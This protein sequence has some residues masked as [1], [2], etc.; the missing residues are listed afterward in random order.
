MKNGFKFLGI[1]AFVAIIGLSMVACDNPTNGDN[2]G[3]GN[4]SGSGGGD[5]GGG[6]GATTGS[7]RVY[8]RTSG[9]IVRITLHSQSTGALLQTIPVNMPVGGNQTIPN[10]QPGTYFVSL[11]D[12]VAVPFPVPVVTSRTLTVSAGD[13]TPWP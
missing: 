6:G 5:T 10:L 13:T 8:N 2:G 4:H 1:I 12:N 3:G 9:T 7:I 11:F